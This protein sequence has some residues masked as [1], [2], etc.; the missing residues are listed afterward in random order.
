[1]RI[2][3]L[4]VVTLALGCAST[5]VRAPA[6]APAPAPAAAPEVERANVTCNEAKV[7]EEH[8]DGSMTPLMCVHLECERLVELLVDNPNDTIQEQVDRWC[9]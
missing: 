3:I 8:E 1:M 2:S 7:M 4:M 5:P 6:A 9:N